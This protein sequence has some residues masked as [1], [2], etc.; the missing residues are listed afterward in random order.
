MRLLDSVDKIAAELPQPVI[1]QHGNTVFRSASCQAI[2]FLS[3][4]EFER[5]IG[6]TKLLIL[7]AGAGSVL[8]AVRAGKIPV[9]VPRSPEFGEHVDWHQLEFARTLA[10]AG[11]VVLAEDPALI[12]DAARTALTL[13]GRARSSELHCRMVELVRARLE[14]YAGKRN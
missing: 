3:M 8:N 6:V 7:H 9:V 10:E 1:V 5:L 2:D 12:R 4:S 13:Q 11:R 14:E